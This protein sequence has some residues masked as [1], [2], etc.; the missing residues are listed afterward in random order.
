ML[1][2]AKFYLNFETIKKMRQMRENLSEED[3]LMLL[4]D[5]R[6]LHQLR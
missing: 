5:V 1:F 6:V 2:T 3:A 4:S